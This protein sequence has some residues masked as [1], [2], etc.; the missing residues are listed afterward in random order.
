MTAVIAPAPPTPGATIGVGGCAAYY[1]A[2]L[3]A[4]HEDVALVGTLTAAAQHDLL[5]RRV[6]RLESLGVLTG[7]EAKSVLSPAATV[8]DVPQHPA[9]QVTVVSILTAALPEPGGVE[10]A[11]AGPLT[12][13]LAAAGGA[14]IGGILAGP[15]GAIIGA[16][17]G[18]AAAEA[19][20]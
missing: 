14:A 19:G 16:A 9:A 6:G 11:A 8:D 7:D 10:F 4:A 3:E 20:L 17:L 13:V 1:I 15:P 12:T 18:V 5:A 2:L